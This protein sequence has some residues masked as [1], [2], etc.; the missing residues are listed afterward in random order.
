MVEKW[1]NLEAE[2]MFLR[3]EVGGEEVFK[4]QKWRFTVVRVDGKKGRKIWR[5]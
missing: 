4:N 5:R 1:L 2:D 3:G